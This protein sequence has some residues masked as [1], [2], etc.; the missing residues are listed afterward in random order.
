MV[1]QWS[2]A[3]VMI[4]SHCAMTVPQTKNRAQG[5]DYDVDLYS[6]LGG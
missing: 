6:Y 3:V 1:C 4:H 2:W 5:R